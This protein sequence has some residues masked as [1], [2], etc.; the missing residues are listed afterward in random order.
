MKRYLK[1]YFETDRDYKINLILSS[2][3]L[4]FVIWLSTGTLSPYALS[5]PDAL[6]LNQYVSPDR[7]DPDP[8]AGV[9][10]GAKEAFQ[11]Q[12]IAN[13]DHGHFLATHLM[14]DGVDKSVWGGSVVLRR[15]LYPVIAYP[16]M[17]LMGFET[18]GIVVNF[19]LYFISFLLFVSF[20]RREI[21]QDAAIFV[22]WAVA[23]FPGVAYFGGLPYSYAFIIPGCLIITILLWNLARAD[24][25][26][27][28]FLLSLGLGIISLGYDFLPIFG[29]AAVLIL[30][31]RKLF[32]ETAVL[33]VTMIAPTVIFGLILKYYYEAPLTNSNTEMYQIIAFSYL[34]VFQGLFSSLGVDPNSTVGMFLAENSPFP[35]LTK[36]WEY[37]KYFPVYLLFN[38]LFS[39]FGYLSAA[40]A[41]VNLPKVF[42]KR[43]KLNSLEFG[44]LLAVFLLFAFNNLAPPYRSWQFRE[45]GFARIYEPMFIVLILYISRKLQTLPEMPLI[46]RRILLGLAAFVIVGNLITSFSTIM[47]NNWGLGIYGNFYLQGATTKQTY[48]DFKRRI[49][50]YGKYPAGFCGAPKNKDNARE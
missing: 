7:G 31:R 6:I 46:K 33:I 36:W 8:N 35:D 42:G 10:P 25:I 1:T 48:S 12:Y 16:F 38:Y 28:I 24:D 47:P 9:I 40:F 29:F 18:G 11:C 4:F 50:K 27:S 17:K 32:R 45:Y 26:K 23:T 5:A 14:L 22:A 43:L 21:G 20:V 41:L 34:G 3:T 49:R 39:T 2:I 19:F 37:L 30:L 44:V 15:I 13:I